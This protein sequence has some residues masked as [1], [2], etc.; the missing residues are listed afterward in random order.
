[1]FDGGIP[2]K[3]GL[4]LSYNAPVTL[5]FALLCLG[6]LGLDWI[7]GG[8]ANKILFSVYRAPLS[9]VFT[10]FRFIGHVFGHG[11][12]AHFMGNMTLLLVLGPNLEDRFGSGNIAVAILATAVVSGLA[13]FMFFPGVALLGASGVVF[14]MVLLS[15]FGGARD[16]TIPVTLVLIAIIYL[17]GE[18]RDAVFVQDDISQ[19][20][21]LIGGACGT[22]LGFVLPKYGRELE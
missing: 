15:S 4:R 12:Y 7:T 3:P 18:I 10:W 16:G 17:G 13:Q 2:R 6:A 9:N 5:T 21:H 1:M 11:G 14:M 22:V 19:A 20:A 8:W